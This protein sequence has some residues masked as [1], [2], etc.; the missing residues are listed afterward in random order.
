MTCRTFLSLSS[1]IKG[2]NIVTG[3]GFGNHLHLEFVYM[4][5]VRVYSHDLPQLKGW[6]QI[7]MT[8]DII[9]IISLMSFNEENKPDF[10]IT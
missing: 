2:L 8:S 1:A 9:F 6:D 4:H 7:T 3:E 5:D 10:V